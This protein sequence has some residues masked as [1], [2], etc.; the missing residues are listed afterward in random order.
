MRARMTQIQGNIRAELSGWR[1]LTRLLVGY[2]LSGRQAGVHGLANGMH[3]P[4]VSLFPISKA[5]V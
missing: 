2:E 5:H 4:Q 3:I 1:S